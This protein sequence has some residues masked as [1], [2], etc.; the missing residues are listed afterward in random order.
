MNYELEESIQQI[1]DESFANGY[2]QALED[3][4][5]ELEKL[6]DKK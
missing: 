4:K 5:K 2:K 3:M 1:A 6:Q